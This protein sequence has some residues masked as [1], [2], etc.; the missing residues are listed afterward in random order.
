M[1]KRPAIASGS[2]CKSS[3]GGGP[4]RT[5]EILIAILYLESQRRKQT[6]AARGKLGHNA[7]RWRLRDRERRKTKTAISHMLARRHVR[8]ALQ[9][10]L[11]ALRTGANATSM[12]NP[13]L[14]SRARTGVRVWDQ[15]SDNE[16]IHGTEQGHAESRMCT[17]KLHRCFVIVRARCVQLVGRLE[18]L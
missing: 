6:R 10:A 8:H 5:Q 11:K 15:R 2:G 4:P 17:I 7:V 3:V 14:V 13:G 16:R 12:N 18:M 1:T 9:N